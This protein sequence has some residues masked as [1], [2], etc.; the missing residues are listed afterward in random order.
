MAYNAKAVANFILDLAN[1]DGEPISPM[2]LQKLIYYAHGWH[3]ALTGEPLI[4][5]EIEAWGYGPVVPSVYRDFKSFG[6]EPITNPAQDFS[7]DDKR[8]I[9]STPEIPSG[10]MHS[11]A[12]Q[13]I[14]RVWEVYKDLSALQLSKMTHDPDAPWSQVVAPYGGKTPISLEIPNELIRKYFVQMGKTTGDNQP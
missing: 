13:I 2:K 1:V 3:L 6:N 5:D 4:S 9:V 7:W 14:K 10:E 8:I 11:S 12:R